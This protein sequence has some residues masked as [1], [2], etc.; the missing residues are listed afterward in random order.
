MAQCF[1]KLFDHQRVRI[2][3][4]MQMSHRWW[5]DFGHAFLVYV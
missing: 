4:I 5:I 1:G 2:S 3:A